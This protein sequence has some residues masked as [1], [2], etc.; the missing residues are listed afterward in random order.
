MARRSH[1]CLTCFL[2]LDDAAAV[3]RT[4]WLSEF[5]VEHEWYHA[6]CL[7]PAPEPTRGSVV[8]DLKPAEVA[9]AIAV[10]C[11]ADEHGPLARAA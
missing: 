7:P 10:D 11:G 6:E 3:V 5:V 1:W 9:F 2:S 8:V 4:H